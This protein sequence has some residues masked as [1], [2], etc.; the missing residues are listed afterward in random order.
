MN[1]LAK[2]ITANN[3]YRKTKPGK[4]QQNAFNERFRLLKIAAPLVGM[5]P[6][7]VQSHVNRVINTF[8]KKFAYKI[9]RNR[10]LGVR[11]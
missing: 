7:V 3:K 9:S 2:L 8:G 4:N 10:E 6:F 5:K 1:T 11:R